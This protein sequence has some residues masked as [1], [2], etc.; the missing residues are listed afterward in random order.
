MDS[1]SNLFSDFLQEQFAAL[2]SPAI[3]MQLGVLIV[4]AALAW[5]AH[6]RVHEYFNRPATQPLPP[7]QRRL[8]H[9]AQILVFPLV[10]LAG[11]LIGRGILLHTHWKIA[12]LNMAVPLLLSLAAIRILLFLLRI[13]LAPGRGLKAWENV[14]G[15]LIW[16][17]VALYLV[18]WLSDMLAWMDE[19]A[20]TVGKARVS[21]LTLGKLAVSVAVWLLLALWL[22]RL[23]EDKLLQS[24][25]LTVGTRLSLTKFSKFML[26]TFAMFIALNSVGIDLTALTIFGGAVGVGLGFG[27]QRVA[28]NLISGF[29]LIF[30]RSI[31]P[32]DVITV[33]KSFGQVKELRA[34]YV[35]VRNRDGLETLIP[36]EN[37]ITAEVINWT[38]TDR[39]VCIK[40]P[41]NISY[42]D[43]PER[44]MQII[45]EL[46]RAHPRVL[47][48]P[49]PACLLTAFGDNGIELELQV[50][51]ND[52]EAGIG[53]VHSDLL[54]AVW[55]AFKQQRISFP[56]PQR[57]TTVKTTPPRDALP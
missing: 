25:Q 13:A 15:T 54:L 33:G 31:R 3:G 34:R 37:L 39:N 18:G 1:S 26:L 53:N 55:Q 47:A 17:L 45:L 28:S 40:L 16:V 9:T 5:F 32:G 20:F 46:A 41:V 24:S 2:S 21:L 4:A 29:I 36:N 52:P 27:L 19:I 38:Y 57:E 35:M 7:L 14:I 11:V 56:F 8:V 30:E 48:D 43:D 42:H 50:W 22:A 44:A 51:I 12:L 10:M 49:A 6:R 23:I